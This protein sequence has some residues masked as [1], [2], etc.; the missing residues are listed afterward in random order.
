MERIVKV[1]NWNLNVE[2][3]LRNKKGIH[4]SSMLLPL[5]WE[6]PRCHYPGSPGAII[7]GNP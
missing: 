7:L 4:I 5:S 1:M 6:T 2:D 3:E